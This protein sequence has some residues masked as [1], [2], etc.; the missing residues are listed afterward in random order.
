[1]RGRVNGHSCHGLT[2]TQDNSCETLSSMLL[3]NFFSSMKNSMERIP[4]TRLSFLNNKNNKWLI[5]KV[6]VTL[7]TYLKFNIVRVFLATKCSRV[8]QLSLSGVDVC[9]THGNWFSFIVHIS[10]KLVWFDNFKKI[11]R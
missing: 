11:K 10:K 5:G 1:M 4:L 2:R 6:Q 9:V 3:G 7:S 8:R